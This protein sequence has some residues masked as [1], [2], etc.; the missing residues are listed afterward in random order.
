ML[1]PV[2][3]SDR[4]LGRWLL[5]QLVTRGDL[6]CSLPPERIMGKNARNG[7]QK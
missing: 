4:D 2:S 5:F 6:G 3:G 7:G 1:L